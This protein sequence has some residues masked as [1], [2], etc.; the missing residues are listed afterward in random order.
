MT[1]K[2]AVIGG[3]TWGATLADLLAANGHDVLLWDYAPEGARALRETRTLKTLPDLKLH[4]AVKVTHDLKEALSGRTALVSAVPSAHVR[5]TWRAARNAGAFSAGAW[6]LS[7]TK[8]IEADTLKRMTEV[9]AEELPAAAGRTAALSGPSHAEEVSR[10]IPTAVVA[11]GPGDLPVR[12]QKLFQSESFRVYTSPDLSGVELGGALKNIY[13]IACGVCDGLGLGDNTKAAL[14]SRGLNEMTRVGLAS[15]AQAMTF[16]GLS[17]LGDLIV[18]CT[19]RHSRNRA[20]GEKIGRG[21]TLAQALAEMT[22]VAEGVATC[23]SGHQLGRKLGLDLPIINE[24]HKCLYEGKPAR[25]A[26][27]D[28]M[29]RPAS[30]EMSQVATLLNR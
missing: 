30:D 10:R 24:I 16:T 20:L 18:T 17:G 19:S 3:G 28:L 13:A 2:A 11:A 1:E 29:T 23:K 4:A 5:G 26:L 27:R 21:K 6:V 25:D 8:G 12:A 7:V 22:M 9:V 14:M 15:G